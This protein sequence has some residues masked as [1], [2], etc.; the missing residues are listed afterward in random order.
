MKKLTLLFTLAFS[1]ITH[2]WLVGDIDYK[3]EQLNSQ[4]YVMHGPM[5]SP[6]HEN[7]G[8]IN[9]PAFIDGDDGL[10]LIDPGSSKLAGDNILNEIEKITSKP[11]I[12]V[13]NT[14][15]HGDHWLGNHS[16][17]DKYPNAKF[18]AHMNMIREAEFGEAERWAQVFN[19]IIADTNYDCC[20][21]Y[22]IMVA[23]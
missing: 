12:A 2:A 1:S 21:C 19:D 14:H 22:V 17:K 4:V 16:I 23:E 10:I 5:A 8:F 11:V 3:F 6:S 15:V 18:Y 7:Y 20:N 13:F 9:N